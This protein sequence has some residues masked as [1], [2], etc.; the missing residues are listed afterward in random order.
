MAIYF[1]DSSALLKAYRNE[2][3]TQQVVQ[4]MQPAHRLFISRLAHVEVAS[5]ITRRGR[6]TGTSP[7][8]LKGLIAE[9]DREVEMR[10]SVIELN[11]PIMRNARRLSE[12]H[13][14]R[15][16]DAVQLSCMM[17][18]RRLIADTEPFTLVSSD[19]ELNAAAA[20]EGL[21]V[22]DPTQP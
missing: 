20:A 8:L 15:G 17:G 9:L 1:F 16:A 4:L 12:L 7:V 18:A 3:G 2:I 21:A 6:A 19:R 10:L 11:H 22:L 5:A 14:L 13:A